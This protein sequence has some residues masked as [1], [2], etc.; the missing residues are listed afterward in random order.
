MKKRK[1]ALLLTVA[2]IISMFPFNAF[3]TEF[4]DM[5]DDW[6]TKALENAVVNGLLKGDDGKIMPKENLTRAQM[7]TIVNR[8]FGTREKTSIDKFTDVKKDAWYFDEMAKAVQMK[9]FIGSGDKLYPDNSIS[10]EEAFIVLARA[11]KL[12][13]GNANILDKFTDKND[14]SDWAREGISSL[15][16]AGYISGSDGRINPKHNITRAEFAQVMYNL[17]KNY[18]NKEGTY[19]EDYDGNLMIN[20]PNVTLKGLTVTGDLI[21]G[22]GVG[23]GE[24]ILDDVTV[25]GR[26]L[27]R[28]GGENSIKIIGNSNINNII[29][30]RVDGKVRIY[31]EDG[32]E[33]GEVIADG[34]DDVIIEGNFESVT[35]VGTDIT[36]TATNATVESASIEGENSKIIIDEKSSVK[37]INVNANNAEISGKGT[38]ESVTANA[39]NV[40][41]TVPGASV[42]AGQG[43]TGVTAGDKPVEPGKTE[44]VKEEKTPVSPGGGGSSYI[45]VSAISVEVVD[46]E[47]EITDDGGTLQLRANVTPT[48]ASN[49]GVIW[50][51]DDERIATIDQTGL[52]T[53][54]ADGDVTVTATAK[55]GSGKKGELV[56]EI[57]EQSAVIVTSDGELATA[58]ADGTKTTII[59]DGDEFN[60]FT[61]TRGMKIVGGTIKVESADNIPGAI[62]KGIYIKTNDQVEIV[63]VEFVDG[64]S[65]HAQRKG[66]VTESGYT[67]DV[68]ISGCTFENL[69][70]GVYFNPGA[71]GSI[72]GNTFDGM[73]HAAI[74]IDSTADVTITGNM[75]ADTVI[76]LEIFGNDEIKLDEVLTTNTLPEGS[77]VVGG[78]ILVPQEKTVYNKNTGAEYEAIQAA[79]NAADEGDTILVGPG[80]YSVSELL[81]ID[82]PLVLRGTSPDLPVVNFGQS[83][84][85]SILVKAD[86]VT[87]EHL[88]LVKEFKGDDNSDQNC[89]LSIPRGGLWTLGY[90]VE[91]DGITLKGLVFEGG[92]TGAYIT[93][94]NLTIEDCLFKDQHSKILYFNIVA[95]DTNVKG[96]TFLGDSGHAIRFEGFSDKET[97]HGGNIT[98]ENNVVEGKSNFL[99]YNGWRYAEDADPVNIR[100]IGNEMRS[101]KGDAVVIWNYFPNLHDVIVLDNDFSGVV[102]GSYGVRGPD[103]TFITATNNYWG[104]ESGPYNG[105]SNPNG[106]GCCVSNNVVYFPWYVNEE[107]SELSP[108]PKGI[109]NARDLSSYRSLQAAINAAQPGDTIFVSEG[110]YIGNLEIG[111][112]LTL[113]ST[114]GSDVTSIK[115]NITIKGDDV[116]N[117][118]IEGFT[119]DGEVEGPSVDLLKAILASNE[120]AQDSVVVGVDDGAK[121]VPSTEVSVVNETQKKG[122][123]NIQEAVDAANEGDTILVGPGEYVED[124]V[125]D[126]PLT[127]LGANANV[128]YGDLRGPESII[129]PK[130]SAQTPIKLS[131]Y[132]TSNNVTINGFEITGEMSNYGIYCGAKGASDLSIQFNYIHDI[133]TG[134]G[135]GNVHAI[136]FR[137]DDHSPKD[138]LIADN[139]IANVLN[140]ASKAEGNSAGIWIGQSTA[141]GMINGIKIERNTINGIYSGK[142]DKYAAGIDIGAGWASSA[143]GGVNAPI[144][145]DNV[146]TEVKG[147]TA[148]GIQLAGKTPEAVVSGNKIS[149]ISGLDS[150]LGLAFGVAVPATNTGA[151]TVEIYDNV[152]ADVDTEIW[153]YDDDIKIAT[154]EKFKAFLE[155][156]RVLKGILTADVSLDANIKVS[157]D[158]ELDLNGYTIKNTSRT[159]LITVGKTTSYQNVPA[160]LTVTNSGSNGGFTT[161]YDLFRVEKESALDVCDCV[162]TGYP[163]QW[164]TPRFLQTWGS[165]ITI[166]FSD[167]NF[168]DGIVSYESYGDENVNVTMV[169]CNMSI[170]TSEHG[171]ALVTF[172]A[173]KNSSLTIA[174]SE[175]SIVITGNGGS[176]IN[177]DGRHN[178]NDGT[179][180]VVNLTDTKITYNGGN[181]AAIMAPAYYTT[182]NMKDCTISSQNS[183]ESHPPAI[184]EGEKYTYNFEG[185]NTINDEELPGMDTGQIATPE[186]FKAFL[187]GDPRAAEDDTLTDDVSFDED[188]NI[189]EDEDEDTGTPVEDEGEIKA[190]ET[191][192]EIEDEEVESNVEE[193]VEES[194]QEE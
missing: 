96:N 139:Y 73:G 34:Y 148:Y 107:L 135:S 158:K 41:V 108:Y 194:E 169:S 125:V 123:D 37:T 106:E 115:G 61:I 120:F 14:I 22:D 156:P 25:T 99:V 42:T 83:Y 89:L 16:A 97:P 74:G 20:V 163:E 162:F 174:D 130:S 18:I 65:G 124:V 176:A 70:M 157:K 47:A 11:F 103:Q 56:V 79:V 133:G 165:N 122:Y 136:N 153:R 101:L 142:S 137:A 182:F 100:V 24:V 32:T 166:K 104:H 17:L 167:C 13:G 54:A 23:D 12:S 93:A 48:N 191:E 5:P 86:N 94:R 131:G 33:V 50:S 88:H 36:V 4:S 180:P 9:T 44:T 188:I 190:G 81:T 66:I 127:L 164:I 10:R 118:T 60:G 57:S 154:A 67:A 27:V 40:E 58:L 31:A 53:A 140:T 186:T 105:L 71:K 181:G 39:N 189:I 95:G 85:E 185:Q 29:I 45:A 175:L 38:V 43:T 187:E 172:E 78:K 116:T 92:R 146:I 19:T 178:A 171:V 170:N 192:Q 151:S 51:V 28:G 6:S 144:I 145:K 55:D 1:L 128:P 161:E 62:P 160:K 138:I 90:Q 111:K 126:K 113:I 59:L 21:I 110:T 7:A 68:T 134:R 150:A 183:S 147:G 193:K 75:V 87:L 132:G 184:P 30:A 109:I 63:G 121:I 141:S 119:I 159:N 112:N 129:K 173:S 2:M 177:V 64:D 3:A 35:I 77:Q 117:V 152:F 52:L 84:K 69:P 8:A 98:I 76:S 15:V 149:N 82:K 155:D 49:K 26:V 179:Q 114:D 72:V 46:G 91:Y 102:E 168:T 80:E 143:T